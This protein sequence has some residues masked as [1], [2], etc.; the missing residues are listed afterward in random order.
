MLFG[1]IDKR[2]KQ[3]IPEHKIRIHYDKKHK[4]NETT[5]ADGHGSR[6]SSASYAL[7]L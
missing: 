6:W 4:N 1:M 7:V 2:N 3:H 5:M